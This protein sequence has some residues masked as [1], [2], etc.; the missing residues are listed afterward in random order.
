M[1]SAVFLILCLP[2]ILCRTLQRHVYVYNGY[3]S[4]ELHV[5]RMVDH[6]RAR[7]HSSYVVDTIGADDVKAGAWAND[8]ALFM[9][10]GGFDLGY[11]HSLGDEGATEIRKYVNDGGSYL[12]QGAGSYFACDRIE[13]DINGLDQVVGDRPLKFYPGVCTG[14]VYSPYSYHDYSSARAAPINFRF[15]PSTPGVDVHVESINMRAY[16][17]GGNTFDIPMADENTRCVTLGSFSEKNDD[18]AIVKCNTYQGLA[19]LTSVH[20]EFG[21][22]HLNSNDEYLGNVQQELRE[23]ESSRLRVFDFL[24]RNLGLTT[25]P[26]AMVSNV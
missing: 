25:R 14:P 10:P 9:M 6:L 21:A 8:A 2:A 5:S 16:Y 11:N 18:P 12:G 13:F 4:D 24:L 3:G 17:N 26:D 22:S 1:Q 23:H 7:L 20:L 19:V 15:I